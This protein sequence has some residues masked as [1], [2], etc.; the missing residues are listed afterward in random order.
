MRARWFGR[1]FEESLLPEFDIEEGPPAQAIDASWPE[2]KN[3]MPPDGYPGYSFGDLDFGQ[4][5]LGVRYDPLNPPYDP[6]AGGC[7]AGYSTR[8]MNVTAYTS[9]PESTGKAPGDP[10]YG[11]G[12]FGKVGPGAIAAPVP[13]Y[14]PDQRMFVPGYGLGTV[15]DTGKAI[16]GDHLDIWLP[17]VQQARQWGRRQ[18]DVDVCD[19]TAGPKTPRG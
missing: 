11:V 12:K 14:H 3:A 9:G 10:A 8:S 5:L 15:R 16:V 19:P 6:G 4:G 1:R 7:P 17:N 2:S 18:I 13:P